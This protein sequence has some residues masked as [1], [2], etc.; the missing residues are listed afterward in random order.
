[1]VGVVD[2]GRL[3]ELGTHA[4]LVAAGGPYA[5]LYATWTASAAAH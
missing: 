4:E 3:V 2:G 1:M 5:A